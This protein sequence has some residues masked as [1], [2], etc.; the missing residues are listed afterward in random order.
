MLLKIT[1]INSDDGLTNEQIH[2][3]GQDSYG[4]L[5]LASPTGLCRYNGSQIK[6]FDQTNG[7][8]CIGLRTVRVS[9]DGMVW[10]GTDQGIEAISIEGTKKIWSSFPAWDYGI[11]E[12]IY[13]NG[14]TIWAGTSFGLL[15]LHNNTEKNELQLLTKEDLG[16]VRC[17]VQKDDHNLLVASAK[18][19][20]L[21]YNTT[22]WQHFNNQD[23]PKGDAVI[24]MACTSDNNVLVGTTGGLFLLDAS[25]KLLAHFLLPGTN[26]KV[27]A[28]TVLGNQWWIG[29]GHSLLAATYN[30]K[31]LQITDTIAV[32]ST[33]NEL[34][35]DQVE[36]VW[37]A[38]NNLGLKKITCLRMALSQINCGKDAAA[39]SI[40][41]INGSDRLQIGGDGFFSTICATDENAAVNNFNAVPGIVWDTCLDPT[42]KYCL[43]VA[44]DDGLLVSKN[45]SAPEK[46]NDPQNIIT[47]PNRV[48]LTR[49]NQIWLGTIAGLFKI[50][51]GKAEEI[52]SAD[53]SHFGYVYTLSLDNN[54]RL[55]VGTLGKGLWIE[56]GKGLEP[57]ANELL[58]PLGNTYSIATNGAG[59]TLVIQVDKILIADKDLNFRLVTTENPVA[60]WSAVWINAT[61]IA[62][63][64]NNGILLIDIET[65][66]IIQRINLHL[67]KSAWQFTS[68]RSLYFDGND[69]LYCGINSG[70][71]IAGIKRFL[72]Y[73]APPEVYFEKAEWR[74]VLP[75]IQGSNY[76]LKTGKWSVTVSVFTNWLVDEEQIRF[77]FK[78]V[79]FDET[80][81]K[82]TAIPVIRYNSLPG[83][84]YQLHCQ[85]FTPLSGYGASVLL[86]NI[87]VSGFLGQLS[88]TPVTNAFIFLNE[89]FFKSRLRNKMLMERNVE[90]ES[91]INERKLAENAL[92]K[93]RQDIRE[94]ASRQEKI[95]EEERL[96]MSREIHDELGQLL[97]GIKMGIAW[98]KKKSAVQE[99][100]MEEKFDETLQL[101]DETTKTVR[102]ISSELR[103][104]ILD[105]FGIV[106]ALEW[107]AAEFEKRSGFKIDFYSNCNEINIDADKAIVLFRIFQET[108]TNVSRYANATII[109][110]SLE[111]E[112]GNLFMRIRDNGQGFV[113]TDIEDKKTL[114]I[115]GMKERAFMIGAGYTITSSPGKGTA[116]EVKFSL[117]PKN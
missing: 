15:Q 52:L 31:H 64:S 85:V 55:W 78:L 115:L 40:K 71:F 77:R 11:A 25:G 68:T 47:G 90:L 108:L 100:N 95:R 99:N 13:I 102:R 43:W 34:F 111:M 19:G 22:G 44:T 109:N 97:T 51:D 84:T 79:G 101:V 5:W 82:Q 17:I 116:T 88:F 63:G 21:N 38:T 96:K 33:I 39:F 29:V 35:I 3:I 14:E 117:H 80:W 57:V 86:M 74:N 45:N 42:D 48:L 83:G 103:P 49:D 8:D 72:Q 53:G 73:A 60:G 92:L 24:C 93:S 28:L 76:R 37:I 26:N 1:T 36:N 7:I 114:G 59:E 87:N 107:Q 113:T 70:L 67:G 54:N 62:T 105:S 41:K 6:I 81:S 16:L 69:N 110:A 61:T 104:G 112:N 27:T 58:S 18:Y 98:L 66:K 89:R 30:N 50:E 20:L 4:R 94:L 12:S 9:P 75:K 91:E 2:A 106:A 23:L 46:F 32:N 56:T 10:I 65:S